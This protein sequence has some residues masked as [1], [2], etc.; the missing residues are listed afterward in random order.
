MAEL[1]TAP[2]EQDLGPE[3]YQALGAFRRAIREFLAFSEAGAR[4]LGLTTQQHQALLAVKCHPGPEPMSIGELADS[5]LIKN[6]SA[7]GLV[8]RLVERDLVSRRP[9]AADRRRVAISLR[10][11][12]EAVIAAISRRNLAQL[13]QA[14]DIMTGLVETARRIGPARD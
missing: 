14:A 8:E 9:F 10:P 11:R 5:L 13:S 2:A 7:V 4:D 6:H 12:G 1:K 3:D